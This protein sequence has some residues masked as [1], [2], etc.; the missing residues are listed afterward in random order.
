MARFNGFCRTGTDQDFHGR[1]SSAYDHY[2]G[3]PLVRPNPNLGPLERAVHRR[4]VVPGDLGTKGG[5]GHRRRRARAPTV[6]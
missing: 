1:G 4:A 6:R 3:D 5:S 2:Y